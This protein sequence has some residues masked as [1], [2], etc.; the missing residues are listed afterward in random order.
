VRGAS[1]ERELYAGHLLPAEQQAEL[2][3][4]VST[5]TGQPIGQTTLD[6]PNGFGLGVAQ[7][8]AEGLGTF[9]LYEGGTAGSAPSTS[10]CRALG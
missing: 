3:S 9:W 6:D 8:T 7:A 2:T 4:L 10:T 5:R 1:G